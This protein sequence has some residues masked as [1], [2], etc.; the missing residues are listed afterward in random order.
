[1]FIGIVRISIK[2][3]FGDEDVSQEQH[4]SLVLALFFPEEFFYTWKWFLL[5]NDVLKL[6][7]IPNLLNLKL[8]VKVFNGW[9]E[10]L[11][12]GTLRSFSE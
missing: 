4:G 10:S 11:N 9:L 1:M 8:Y 7:G 2:L 12:L 6:V 3:L 5:N